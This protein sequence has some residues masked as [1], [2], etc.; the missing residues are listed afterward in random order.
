MLKQIQYVTLAVMAATVV[1]HPDLAPAYGQSTDGSGPDDGIG[2]FGGGYKYYPGRSF[3]FDRSYLA[4]RA[5]SAY[6]GFGTLSNG[7]PSPPP[8]APR[9]AALA[10]AAKSTTTSLANKTNESTGDRIVKGEEAFRER[11]YDGAIEDWW[12]E[13]AKGNDNPVL[14]MMLGQAFFAA[15]RY[16]EA[17]VTTQAAMHTLSPDRWGVVVSNRR[18]LYND[19]RDYNVQLDQL[20]NA[21]HAKPDDAPQRF[22]LGYHYACL[23]YPQ[24]AL[25]Q[26]DQ[27][28]KLEP[29]DEMAARLRDVLLS[30]NPHPDAPMITPGPTTP[31]RT[32]PAL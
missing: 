27:V 13:L 8:A 16:R 28:V 20:E 14:Q 24:A 29:R 7:T 6:G 1:C 23:G 19:S 12:Y 25:R 5:I 31:E 4:S 3:G 30:H 11:D 21:V 18:E 10:R 15:G 26:L 17:A 32:P 22:L 2:A 9:S